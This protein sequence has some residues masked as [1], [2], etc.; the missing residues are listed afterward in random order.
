[1]AADLAPRNPNLVEE[2][3]KKQ[4][5]IEYR[6]SKSQELEILGTYKSR[7]KVMLKAREDWFLVCLRN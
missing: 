3:I 1:M 4:S 6:L 5:D 2:E 7:E